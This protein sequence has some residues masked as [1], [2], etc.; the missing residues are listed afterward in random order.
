MLSA[1][2]FLPEAGW[3]SFSTQVFRAGWHTPCRLHLTTAFIVGGVGAWL[4]LRERTNLRARIM[5]SMAMSMATLV[6]P[7]QIV[8]GD[9]HGLN[10]LEHQPAKVMAMEG[11]YQSHPNGAPLI[12]FGIPN[13][14]ENRIDYVI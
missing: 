3:P 12:L 2:T 5:F 4:L 9:L 7:L 1:S 6:G 8:L 14:A 10:T 11:H 13:S